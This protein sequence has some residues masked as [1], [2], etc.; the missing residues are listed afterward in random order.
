MQFFSK[1]F[2]SAWKGK[3]GVFYPI[4]IQFM[5]GI[6]RLTLYLALVILVLKLFELHP[7]S[8]L[9]FSISVWGFLF[10]FFNALAWWFFSAS[11][12]VMWFHHFAAAGS[13]S[14]SSKNWLGDL[15]VMLGI[16]VVFGVLKWLNISAVLFGIVGIFNNASQLSLISVAVGGVLALIC[17]VLQP[18][19]TAQRMV[20]GPGL[21]NA[22]RNAVNN[23]VHFPARTLCIRFLPGIVSISCYASA[24]WM[25][26]IGYGMIMLFLTISGVVISLIQPVFWTEL[27]AC[28]DNSAA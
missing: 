21:L 27:A 12:R 15:P 7:T 2:E 19:V 25:G 3:S 18:A 14:R 6:L 10:I 11:C 23:I 28:S 1:A 26:L 13:P 24:I 5:T 8:D 4:L 16:D 17:S 9:L 20:D 22:V